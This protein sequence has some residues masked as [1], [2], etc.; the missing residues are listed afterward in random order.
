MDGSSVSSPLQDDF[1]VSSPSS[2]MMSSSA[3]VVG[4]AIPVPVP[5][6]FSVDGSAPCGIFMDGG[7]LFPNFSVDSFSE[8]M[9]SSINSHQPHYWVMEDEYR[10]E[11]A[12]AP[13]VIFVVNETHEAA[14]TDMDVTLALGELEG[15]TS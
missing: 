12:A 1:E 11:A 13:D 10:K 14:M 9:A 5:T 15:L 7:H 6:I 2:F 3:P 8:S 4:L